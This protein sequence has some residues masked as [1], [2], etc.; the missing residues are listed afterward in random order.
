MLSDSGQA[1]HTLGSTLTNLSAGAN[2][3]AQEA[4]GNMRTV[5]AFNGQKRTIERYSKVGNSHLILSMFLTGKI[6]S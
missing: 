1:C 3:L 4:L 5:S 6:V 2:S